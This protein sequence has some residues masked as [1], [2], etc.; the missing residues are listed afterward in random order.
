MPSEKS[1][2]LHPFYTRPSPLKGRITVVYEAEYTRTYI[3]DNK[4]LERP[5]R[6]DVKRLLRRHPYTSYKP[7]LLTYYIGIVRPTVGYLLL[8]RRLRS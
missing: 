5:V 6:N 3:R 4:T 8:L 1:P 7:R 2:A